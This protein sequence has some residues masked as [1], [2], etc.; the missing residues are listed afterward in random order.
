MPASR[1]QKSLGITIIGAGNLA[2]ALATALRRSRYRILEVVTRDSP[3]SLRHARSLASRVGAQAATLRDAHFTASVT[4]ICVPDDAIGDVALQIAMDRDWKGKTVLHS[5]GAIDSGVLD[6]VR[7]R[8]AQ[9]GSAHPLMTFVAASEPDLHGVPFALEGDAK[10]LALATAVVSSIGGK[11]FRID[12]EVKP[13]YHAF[14]FF[15]SPAIVALI[16]AAQE[17]GKL[18]GFT[19]HHARELMEPIVRQTIENCFQTNPRSAFSGPIKRGD[20]ATI[21]KHLQVLRKNRELL[22]LYRSLGRIALEQLPGANV[23]K[24]GDLFGHKRS[25][26][27][28]KK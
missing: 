21:R 18:A 11:P 17:V 6:P 8:G 26:R 9:V 14:G 12:P 7:R 25:N 2:T 24:L 19:E 28:R 1:Q 5:S 20:V 23:G 16:V 15:S 27:L 4:W 3:H 10:A 22:D 13:A